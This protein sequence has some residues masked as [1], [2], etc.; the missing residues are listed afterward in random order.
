MDLMIFVRIT[1]RFSHE[2]QIVVLT[3][4]LQS[5]LSEQSPNIK[6][7]VRVDKVKMDKV[8]MARV[9]IIFD[10]CKNGYRLIFNI[11]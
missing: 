9:K 7:K 8:K 5:E 10:W 6:L 4:N 1:V 3:L 11:R 2:A